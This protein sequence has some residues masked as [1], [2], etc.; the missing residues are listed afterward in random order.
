[1]S[2]KTTN[3]QDLSI[4]DK[5]ESEFDNVAKIRAELPKIYD[6]ESMKLPVKFF[7][8]RGHEITQDE[9]EKP[10]CKIIYNSKGQFLGHTGM[11]YESIQPVNFLDSFVRSIEGCDIEK[12]LDLSK[13]QYRDYAGGKVSEFYLPIEKFDLKPRGQRKRGDLVNI[14]ISAITGY[15]GY[16]VSKLNLFAEVLSCLNGM[17]V[18]ESVTVLKAKHTAKMNEKVMLF[19][20]EMIETVANIDTVTES[21]EQMNLKE[22]S[23]GMVIN[24]AKKLA[25]IDLKEKL[26]D[27]STRKKNIYNFLRESIASEMSSKGNTVWGLMNGATHYTNHVASGSDNPDYIHIATGAKLNEQAQRQALE[28]IAV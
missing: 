28:L 21:W 6:I 18:T 2:N 13:L 23:E 10:E 4:L 24:F 16:Q 7:N 5:I 1:M 9:I 8:D 19:C 22:V 14:G 15:G 17:T 27:Q 12:N 3:K 20:D 11:N 26:E 25:Q